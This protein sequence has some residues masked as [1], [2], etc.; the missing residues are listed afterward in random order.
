MSLEESQIKLQQLSISIHVYPTAGKRTY[1]PK[2][3]VILPFIYTAHKDILPWIKQN[4]E[5]D[6]LLETST[7]NI[8]STTTTRRPSTSSRSANRP[9]ANS[10]GGGFQG[11]GANSGGGLFGLGI[12]SANSGWLLLKMMMLHWRLVDKINNQETVLKDISCISK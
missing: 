1:P 4:L 5:G 3:S 6:S 11:F 8:R 12:N 10:G 7:R 2:I 9:P